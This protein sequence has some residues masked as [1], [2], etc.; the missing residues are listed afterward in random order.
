M[1]SAAAIVTG[2]VVTGLTDPRVSQ[3]VIWPQGLPGQ[4]NTA[5]KNPDGSA[6]DLTTATSFQL[7]GRDRNGVVVLG[8]RNLVP[9]TLSQGLSYFPITSGDTSSRDQD[10]AISYTAL[11]VDGSG[12]IFDTVGPSRFIVGARSD[13]GGVI[14]VP[15]PSTT[16]PLV[17][18]S[19][20]FQY[21]IKT[22]NGTSFSIALPVALQALLVNGNYAV[23]FKQAD[24]NDDVEPRATSR[25]SSSFT[26]NLTNALPVGALLDIFITPYTATP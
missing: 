20:S 22:G 15:I 6:Y 14:P 10:T 26:C 21:T 2:Y 12:K 18:G 1:A 5:I 19:W 17:F 16:N 8:P 11:L 9:I 3:D 4:F 25:T 24:L 13:T 7:F 23:T